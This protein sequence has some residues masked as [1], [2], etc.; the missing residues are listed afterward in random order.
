MWATDGERW[1]W[2]KFMQAALEGVVL[3]P[4]YQNDSPA[5]VAL[6]AAQI[7]DAAVAEYCCRRDGGSH[8]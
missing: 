1:A 8:G 2:V 7:A 4:R 5:E 6:R 3:I